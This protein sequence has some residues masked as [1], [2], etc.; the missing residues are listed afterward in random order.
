MGNQF[1]SAS[2]KIWTGLDFFLRGVIFFLG[3]GS[4]RG[5]IIFS[6]L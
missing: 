2:C 3:G 5:C 6:S 4:E 1:S